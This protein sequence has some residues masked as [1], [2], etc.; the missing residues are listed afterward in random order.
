M[1]DVVDLFHQAS[2]ASLRSALQVL[3]SLPVRLELD[4]AAPG[5]DIVL[6]MPHALAAVGL[7]VPPIGYDTARVE[8][9]T[10]VSYKHAAGIASFH[11][12]R[13]EEELDATDQTR[14]ELHRPPEA[15]VVAALIRTSRFSHALFSRPARL[16]RFVNAHD[17]RALELLATATNCAPSLLEQLDTAGCAISDVI[18]AAHAALGRSDTAPSVTGVASKAT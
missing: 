4:M 10:S 13:T 17:P 7:T 11:E 3:D 6:Q 16:L 14:G 15:L 8:L 18:A 5:L 1:S 2:Q 9:I 12:G